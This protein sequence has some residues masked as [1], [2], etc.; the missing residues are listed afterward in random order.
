MA[1]R[2]QLPVDPIDVAVKH[3]E[4]HGWDEAAPGMGVLTS[5][6]RVQQI[7]AA[8]VDQVVRPHGLTFA[9]YE[10]LMLL[11]FSRRGALPLGKIGERLQVHPASVTNAVAK[12]EQDG[13]I[14][15]RPNP[16]DGRGALA[17]LTSTGRRV[18]QRATRSLNDEVFSSVALPADDLARVYDL[19]KQLRQAA[20]DFD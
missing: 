10:V 16:A 4:S 17:E 18:A 9:R 8:Q 14:R 12:L 7:F 11:M 19:L 1:R 3:W 2:R 15:R 13:L 6:M 5:I 20:G